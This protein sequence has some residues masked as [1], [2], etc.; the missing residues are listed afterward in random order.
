MFGNVGFPVQPIATAAQKVGITNIGMRKE[1]AASYTEQAAGYLTGVP[2]CT[3]LPSKP[4]SPCGLDR[5][6]PMEPFG[7]LRLGSLASKR[8]AE[9]GDEAV[10]SF[11]GVRGDGERLNERCQ[12][13]GRAARPCK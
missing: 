12:R 6:Y 5:S 8:P 1:Q 11:A 7:G 10:A 13:R 9:S 2:R 4:C 3:N